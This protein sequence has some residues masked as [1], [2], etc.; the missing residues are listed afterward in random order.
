L[1]V[2]SQLT[3]AK[4]NLSL[5]LKLNVTFPTWKSYA[6]SIGGNAAVEAGIAMEEENVFGV[7]AGVSGEGLQV[8]SKKLRSVLG[9]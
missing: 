1:K 9:G 8:L 3:L 2:S 5:K 7:S 6:V 4:V